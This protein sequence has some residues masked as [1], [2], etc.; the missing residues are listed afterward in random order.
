MSKVTLKDVAREAGVS[1]MSVSKALNNKSGVSDDTRQRI[2]QVAQQMHYTQNQVARSLRVDETKT[3]GVVLSDCSEMVATKVLRGIQDVAA[4]QGYSVILSN[5]NNS[6]ETER[7]AVQTLVSKRIDGLALVAPL[8]Y[9]NESIAWLE[10]FGVPF[11]LLMRQNGQST[12]DTIIND[13]YLG[14]Y[15]TV[16]HLIQEGCKSFAFLLLRDSIIS[17]E[18]LNGYRQAMRDARIDCENC[19]FTEVLPFYGEGFAA[20]NAMLDQ[21]RQ[22]DA[23]VC[24][25]DAVAIGAMAALLDAGIRIPQDICITGYDGVDFCNYL[26]VP[27]TTVAQPF[28][29]IG[30]QGAE[31]LLDR[32]KYAQSPVRKLV[33]KSELI[34]RDS[35]RRG[36]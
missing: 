28:Y 36:K 16:E 17:Q 13:N 33:L 21:V 23:M 7:A 19:Y 25:C 20:A 10:G 31:V 6:G 8:L 35:S 30:S 4:R 2:L 12:V 15:Q 27:L 32:I 1:A 18:R 26:R 22:Y 29:E 24:A 34:V 3:I 14:G 9:A 5:A 11:V